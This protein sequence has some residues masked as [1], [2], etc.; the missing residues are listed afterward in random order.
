MRRHVELVEDIVSIITEDRGPERGR[1][2]REK[3]AYTFAHHTC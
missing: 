1:K 3:E 2:K